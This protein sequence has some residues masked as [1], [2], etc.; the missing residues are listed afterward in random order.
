MA[1]MTIGCVDENYN[2]SHRITVETRKNSLPQVLLILLAFCEKNIV[3]YAIYALSMLPGI[4]FLSD[5]ILAFL[6]VLLILMCIN[7]NTKVGLSELFVPMFV[8]MAIV[9]TCVLYPQNAQYIMDPNRFWN[10]IFPCLRW[11]IVGLVI[12]PDKA[13]MT[14][15]GKATC[16]A[17]ALETAYLLFYMVPNGLISNDD[18]SR[19]YQLLPHIM[20]AFAY[21]FNSKKIVPWTASIIGLLYLLSLGTRGPFLV[22][23]VY[24]AF[25]FVIMSVATTRRKITLVLG[26]SLVGLLISIPDVYISMLNI[27]YALLTKI[28]VSTRIVDYM[29]EGTI[30]SNTTGRDELY[31]FALEKI[32]E[33]PLL[34]YGVYGEWQW[35]GWNIHNMYLEVLL[36]FGVILG[37]F[38]LI[39]LIVYTVGAFFKTKNE[40]AKDLLLIFICFVFIRSFYGG[41][42]LHYATYFLIALSIKE[43][44]RER[45]RKVVINR[46]TEGEKR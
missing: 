6:Y 12:I 40:Y 45:E 7:G 2:T 8:I 10:T 43:R 21:A 29:I 38:L 14:L 18:M 35:I 30:V 17:I 13:L 36:H 25:K 20:V 23:L 44:R 3:R 1:Q 26:V 24:I 37:G 11:F 28:G 32:A 31:A 4:G 27:L 39:W 9:F 46:V 22:L 34:G 19:A 42:Y 33:K 16:I 15:L 5:Y 41:S